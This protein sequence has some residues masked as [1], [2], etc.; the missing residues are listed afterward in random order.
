[1]IHVFNPT[2]E[3]ATATGNP[4]YEPPA[5]LKKFERDL[6]VLPMVYAGADDVVAVYRL[7][8]LSFVDYLGYCNF[9]VSQF[10]LFQ[11]I[12]VSDDCN[13]WGWAP[14]ISICSDV[15]QKANASKFLTR[16]NSIMLFNILYDLLDS[17]GKRVLSKPFVHRSFDI[18]QRKIDCK[19][20]FVLKSFFSSSGRGVLF[21]D[22]KVDIGRIQKSQSIIRK[23]GA[24]IEEEWYDRT[25]DFS[26]HFYKQGSAVRFLGVTKLLVSKKGEYIGNVLFQNVE[27]Q[28][29][30]FL[31][32]NGA[33]RY[34]N[35][36]RTIP[37]FEAY[38]G[39][40]GID[41]F[42]FRKNGSEWLNPC[43][44]VNCRHTMGYVAK[45]LETYVHPDSF[46]VFEVQKVTQVHKNLYLQLP[47]M[48]D[49]KI[50]SGIVFLTPIYYD[51]EF[52]AVLNVREVS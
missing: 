42:L 34:I 11:K 19:K 49:Q 26:I 29:V 21:F 45:L 32:S 46:A 48:K 17:D 15:A 6:C 24:I 43:A 50:K 4:Y 25:L 40:I 22:D 37:N 7:P 47:E 20:A 12:S 35:A 16:Q 3:I 18:I 39:P 36:I 31:F 27:H 8:D 14:N 52:C 33:E 10:E 23:Q 28:M 5:I 44:E 38:S 9:A 2:C 51:T 41:A 13:P 30:S 1:M